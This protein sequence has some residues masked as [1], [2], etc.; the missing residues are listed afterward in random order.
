VQ[1]KGFSS[2]NDK[3]IKMLHETLFEGN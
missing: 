2:N 3:N 1:G